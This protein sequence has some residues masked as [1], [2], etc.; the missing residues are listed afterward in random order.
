[1]LDYLYHFPGWFPIIKRFQGVERQ[2]AQQITFTVGNMHV[3]RRVVPNPPLED[4]TA[5]THSTH[6]FNAWFDLYSS[7]AT[8]SLKAWLKQEKDAATERPPDWMNP[9]AAAPGQSS[10]AFRLLE[11]ATWLR[12][13]LAQDRWTCGR[14]AT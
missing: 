5:S 3:L 8:L 2:P 13:W 11:C 7:V 9:S 10:A 14:S 12:I 1:L 4:V 6:K